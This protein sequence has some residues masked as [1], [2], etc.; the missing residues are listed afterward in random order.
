MC[1]HP[2]PEQGSGYLPKEP[3]TRQGYEGFMTRQ[4][5]SPASSSAS[6]GIS[7]IEFSESDNPITLGEIGNVRLNKIC[8]INT[9]V[10]CQGLFSMVQ[11]A[12]VMDIPHLFVEQQYAIQSESEPS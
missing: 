4:Q 5:G 12:S 3:T 7:K 11:K 8:Y 6:T 1:E 10:L 9:S 2:F